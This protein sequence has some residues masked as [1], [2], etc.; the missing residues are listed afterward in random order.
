MCGSCVKRFLADDCT[1]NNVWIRYIDHMKGHKMKSVHVWNCR[2]ATLWISKVGNVAESGSY[3][4][5]WNVFE[6]P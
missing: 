5:V 6:F 2:M 4:K 3:M 1:W